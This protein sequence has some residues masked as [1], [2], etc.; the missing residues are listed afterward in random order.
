[1]VVSNFSY[2]IICRIP[3]DTLSN[4][5]PY[6]TIKQQVVKETD[7]SDY[8]RSE[9]L[10]NLPALF[11]QRPSELLTFIRNLQPE[12]DCKWYYSQYQFLSQMPPI[13]RAQLVSK[14][15]L[16]VDDDI[17]LLKT[18]INNPKAEAVSEHLLEEVFEIRSKPSGKKP[19]AKKSSASASTSNK[20]KLELCWFHN[21][22]G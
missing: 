19:S 22:F 3:R 14:K 1:M 17:S 2:K 9:K 8:Q 13:M 11:D 16:S 12:P 18:A 5:G 7:L 4:P 21:R 10:H 15:D 20:S 6:N